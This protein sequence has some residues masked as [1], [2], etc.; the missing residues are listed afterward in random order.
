[1]RKISMLVLLAAFALVLFQGC[2]KI[3]G[4]RFWWDDRNQ[5]VLEGYALP[6]NPSAPT[7]SGLERTTDAS[8][9]DLSEENLKDYRTNIDQLEE[10]RKSESSLLDF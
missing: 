3:K 9:Q 7:E 6:A 2:G 1:M 4:P 5:E 8:G 10:K